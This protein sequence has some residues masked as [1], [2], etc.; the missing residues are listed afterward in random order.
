M[1]IKLKLTSQA[2]LDKKF[3]GSTPGYNPLQVDEYIDRIIRDYKTVEE[4]CLM[5]QKEAGDL[6]SQVERL[7]EENKKLSIENL[8]FKGRLSNVVEADN[9]T[10]ENLNLLKRIDSL[11][12]FIYAKGFDPSKIK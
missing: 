7:T 5:L 1:P 10:K 9:V 4:N 12:K 8:K 2:I 6:N 3:Q 11:E